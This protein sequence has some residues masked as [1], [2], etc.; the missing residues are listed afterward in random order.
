MSLVKYFLKAF[1]INIL[2]YS[3]KIVFLICILIFKKNSIPIIVFG[4][5]L[6]VFWILPKT[7][8]E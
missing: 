6:N 2:E 5:L 4:I 8:N 1:G 7:D 3:W